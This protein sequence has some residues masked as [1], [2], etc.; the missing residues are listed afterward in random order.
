MFVALELA[1]AKILYPATLARFTNFQ[2]D[3]QLT[4]LRRAP[5]GF[6]ASPGSASRC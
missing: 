4:F 2:Q 6:T 5:G 1:A 3:A